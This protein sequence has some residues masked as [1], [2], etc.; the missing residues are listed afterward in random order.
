MVGDDALCRTAQHGIVPDHQQ[1]AIGEV[2]GQLQSWRLHASRGLQPLQQVELAVK[3]RSEDQYLGHATVP[4]RTTHCMMPVTPLATV[5]VMN[6][7]GRQRAVGDAARSSVNA[8]MIALN[9]CEVFDVYGHDNI[10]VTVGI[11]TGTTY[12][13]D[14]WQGLSSEARMCGSMIPARRALAKS[15]PA[16]PSIAM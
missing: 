3:V 16:R 15:I 8:R 10:R 4:H 2:M 5:D 13:G 12:R 11:V 1:V 7:G 14:G 9:R 6:L